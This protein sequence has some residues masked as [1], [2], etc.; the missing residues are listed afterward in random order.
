MKSRRCIPIHPSRDGILAAKASTL[1]G[2]K[3]A[4]RELSLGVANV[5]VGP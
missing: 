4:S 1:I 2:Q 3:P 5:S